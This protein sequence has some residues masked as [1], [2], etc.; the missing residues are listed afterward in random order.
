MAVLVAVG[1]FVAVLVDVLVDVPVDVAVLVAV[2]VFVAV[3]VYVFVGVA[4]AGGGWVSWAPT[5][6]F[7]GVTESL[8]AAAGNVVRAMFEMRTIVPDGP[9]HQRERA[10]IAKGFGHIHR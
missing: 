5:A 1:V 6:I 10:E 3:A 7:G 9:L 4:V 2:A 8:N